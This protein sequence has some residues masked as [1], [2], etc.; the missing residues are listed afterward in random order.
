MA[1]RT[2]AKAFWSAVTEPSGVTAFRGMGVLRAKGGKA[3]IAQ[4]SI[5]ALQNLAGGQWAFWSAV[6][7]PS[8]VTAFPGI[9]VLR[10]E[11]GKA[12]I[13]QSSIAA[14]QNLAEFGRPQQIRGNCSPL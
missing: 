9:G 6:T 12:A 8:G 2:D 14:L 1:L 3:A 11:G 5:A 13:A 4:S 10:A 7:E